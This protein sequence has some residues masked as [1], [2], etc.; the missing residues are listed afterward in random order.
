MVSLSGIMDMFNGLLNH[1][2]KLNLKTLPSQGIFYKDDFEIR[3]KKASLEDIIEYD[4]TFDKENIYLVVESLKKI[5]S[6]NVILSKGYT[7]DDIKSVDTV[8][9]FLEIV[10]F[11]QNKKINIDYFDE[12]SQKNEIIEFS[13]KNF[14][15][16]NFGEYERVPE[17]AEILIDGYRFSMPSIGVENCLT[18]FLLK[19]IKLNQKSEWDTYSYDFIFFTGNKGTLTFEEMENLV[20]IFNYDLDSKEQDKISKITNKFM[21]I[22]GYNLKKGGRIIEIKSKIDLEK[23]WK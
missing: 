9:L 23:I 11:T 5:I 14:N 6:K 18:H 20:T 13:S 12:E 2:K 8:F 1:S 7:I 21:K 3:I 16:F 15:Y 4:Q 17:T 10:K 19:K 22:V